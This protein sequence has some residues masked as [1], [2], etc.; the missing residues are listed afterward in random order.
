MRRLA[1]A[2]VI[3]LAAGVTLTACTSTASSPA[4]TKSVVQEVYSTTSDL[5]QCVLL[6]KAMLPLWSS[7]TYA[8]GQAAWQMM[9]WKLQP[10]AFMAVD[11]ELQDAL[12][13]AMDVASS[14][15]YDQMINNPDEWS[16]AI[17]NA[18]GTCDEVIGYKFENLKAA[19]E[20]RK[21]G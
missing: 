16:E 2:A 13:V 8:S 15:S 17:G 9:A 5:E 20:K 7:K 21:V 12:Y 14:Q 18:L 4:P 3:M 6:E 10:L 11:S 1:L 19:V